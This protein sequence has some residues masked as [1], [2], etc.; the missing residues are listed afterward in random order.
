MLL[1]IPLGNP[2]GVEAIESQLV[3]TSGGVRSDLF[4]QLMM[5]CTPSIGTCGC[6]GCNGGWTEGAHDHLS[7]ITGLTDSIYIFREL[8]LTEQTETVACPTEKVANIDGANQMLEDSYAQ[9]TGYHKVVLPRTSGVHGTQDLQDSA[10]TLEALHAPFWVNSENWNVCPSTSD[11]VR[12]E[13]WACLE[14]AEVSLSHE[15]LV[16]AFLVSL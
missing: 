12:F 2:A 8:S 3:L 16:C 11:K 6:F 4:D 5:S 15:T 9:V 13:V 14:I 1:E 10:A 7:N